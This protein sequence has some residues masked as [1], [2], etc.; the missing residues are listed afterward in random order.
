MPLVR[1]VFVYLQYHSYEPLTSIVQIASLIDNSVF[2]K[3][4]VNEKQSMG[5]IVSMGGSGDITVSSCLFDQNRVGD[6]QVLWFP[7][8]SDFLGNI[9]VRSCAFS[10][11]L[12]GISLA[13]EK[14]GS[15]YITGCS[16]LGNK[17]TVV[18]VVGANVGMSS[19]PKFMFIFIKTSLM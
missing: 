3:N 7:Y 9:T 15:G 13:L 2:R 6:D 5:A 19:S 18:L 11:T 8:S 10:G 17:N 16:F 12:G 1:W 4:R 14:T